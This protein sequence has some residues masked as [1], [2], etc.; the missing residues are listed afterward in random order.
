MRSPEEM[1]ALIVGVAE[2]DERIRAVLLGGS[3]TDP[4]TEPDRYQDFDAVYFVRD[5]TP[6]WD[7]EAWIEEQFGKPALLQKPES[8]RLTPPDG[9]GNY[10]Y[11]MLF[12]DGNRIDLQITAD[13]Y[14]DDGEPVRLL[15]DK[16]GV[17]P[18]LKPKREYWFVERPD[19]KLF[20]DCANEF[21]WCLQNVAKGLAR[22]EIS[23]AMDMRDRV[24]RDMLIKMISWRIGAERGFRV[25]V[26]KHGKRF[27]KLLPPE[28]YRAFLETYSSAELRDAWNATEKMLAFFSREARLVASSLGFVYPEKEEKAAREYFLAVRDESFSDRSE[29]EKKRYN[30]IVL[31]DPTGEKLLM[32]RRKKE[33]FKGLLN[34]VGGKVEE[35]EDDLSAAYRELFEETGVTRADI[36]LSP[37]MELRYFEEGF[38]LIVFAG[39][40]RSAPVLKEEINPLLWV[41]RREDFADGTRFAG[42]GNIGHILETV[43]AAE[44]KKNAKNEREDEEDGAGSI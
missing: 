27:R 7:N 14:A 10:A 1:L 40:L 15:L 32:C 11:L 2:K 36:S 3:R 24:V 23:Y 29:G 28:E 38:D 20:S 6:F 17:F 39:R 26:G 31:Y 41:D 25:S 22:N 12:P 21:F 37:V 30:V 16:D 5:V 13:P 44:K 33:P 35:G 19:Q 34:F 9:D 42:R 43:D 8:M 4:D 18:E